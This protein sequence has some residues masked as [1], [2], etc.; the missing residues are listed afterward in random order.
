MAKKPSAGYQPVNRL[1]RSMLRAWRKAFRTLRSQ[2]QLAS[3][4]RQ[5]AEIQRGSSFLAKDPL[6]ALVAAYLAGRRAARV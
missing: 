1:E 2:N 6:C 4:A 5:A 3:I